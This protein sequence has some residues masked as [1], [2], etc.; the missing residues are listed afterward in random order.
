[1][2]SA[3]MLPLW[4]GLTLAAWSD[5]Q[6]RKVPN[7]LTGPLACAGLILAALGL[8]PVSLWT[9]ILAMS[10]AFGLMV[11]PF[12]LRLFLGGDL[13][14]LVAASAWLTPRG[15]VWAFLIGI[16]AG[17]VW[18]LAQ[19][20]FRPSALRRL[21]VEIRLIILSAKFTAPEPTEAQGTVP[22]A[23]TFGL[24]VFYAAAGY[25]LWP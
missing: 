12:T 17:G 2:L 16:I 5:V 10:V 1:M 20:L 13:K 22:M 4:I 8:G 23:V 3:A 21:I 11:L 7:V 18:G 15:V 19:V 24:G 9:A 14:L 25:R 6:H